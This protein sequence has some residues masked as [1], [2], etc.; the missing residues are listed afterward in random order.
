MIRD[1]F[2][3]FSLPFFLFLQRFPQRRGRRRRRPLVF[4]RQ[5]RAALSHSLP[6]FVIVPT[7]VF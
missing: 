6:S 5:S 2:S 3:Y 4:V 1:F 7:E